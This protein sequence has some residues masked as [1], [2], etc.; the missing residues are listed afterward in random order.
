MSVVFTGTSSS[1]TQKSGKRG[2]LKKSQSH[3]STESEISAVS[4]QTTSSQGTSSTVIPETAK[5]QDKR[6]QSLRGREGTEGIDSTWILLPQNTFH[7]PQGPWTI[8]PTQTSDSPSAHKTILDFPGTSAGSANGTPPSAQAFQL[9]GSFLANSGTN[10]CWS[11]GIVWL[12]SPT[13]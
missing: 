13:L 12:Y 3:V 6:Y 5:V 7:Q 8:S 4:G 1:G 10:P 11:N 2:A 9:W